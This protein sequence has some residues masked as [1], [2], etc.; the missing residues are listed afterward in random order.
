M[1]NKMIVITELQK[2]RE[3]VNKKGKMMYRFGIR[4]GPRYIWC[5]IS[6]NKIN[7]LKENVLYELEITKYLFSRKNLYFKVNK[8]REIG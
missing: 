8:I 6:K 7:E 5:S 2:I 1:G 4:V 3:V